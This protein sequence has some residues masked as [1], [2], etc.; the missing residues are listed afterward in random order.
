MG[1]AESRGP[2]C[3][4]HSERLENVPGFLCLEAD[5]KKLLRDCKAGSITSPPPGLIAYQPA[6]A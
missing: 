5:D 2:F 4:Q 1:F 3:K 6:P